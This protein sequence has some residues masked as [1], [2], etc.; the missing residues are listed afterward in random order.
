MHFQ[1]N[2]ENW[3]EKLP[4]IWLT[5]LFR[6][7]QLILMKDFKTQMWISH[8][9][10]DLKKII[11]PFLKRPWGPQTSEWCLLKMLCLSPNVFLLL[12]MEIAFFPHKHSARLDVCFSRRLFISEMQSSIMMV[13]LCNWVKEAACRLVQSAGRSLSGWM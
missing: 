2:I 13:T 3:L 5:A 1:Q 8:F 7:L 11:F 6:M 9:H 12:K 10:V 4:E